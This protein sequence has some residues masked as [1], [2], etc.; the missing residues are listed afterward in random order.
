MEL[1]IV[2]LAGGKGKRLWPLTNEHTPKP[3]LQL[4]SDVPLLFET[5]LRLSPLFY[6]FPL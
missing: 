2:I 6:A 1:Q 3:M 4:F 5:I